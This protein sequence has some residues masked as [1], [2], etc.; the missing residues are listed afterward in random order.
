MGLNLRRERKKLICKRQPN[1]IVM[2]ERAEEFALKIQSI[3]STLNNKVDNDLEEAYEKFTKV[4]KEA[5][6]DVEGTAPRSSDYKLIM[7]TKDLI[8]K[9]KGM[10]IKTRWEEIELVELTIFFSNRKVS[11]IRKFIIENVEETLRNGRSLK[12]T[13]RRLGI[14]RYELFVLK[15]ANGNVKTNM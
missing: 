15:D 10:I 1:T 6:L 13:K 8:N 14:G 11:E 4:V 5:A 7:E 3:F 12:T 9:R 2:R